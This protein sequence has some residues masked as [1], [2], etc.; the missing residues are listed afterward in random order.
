MRDIEDGESFHRSDKLCWGLPLH[1]RTRRSIKA[2]VRVSLYHNTNVL[3][4]APSFSL[5][6][7]AHDHRLTDIYKTKLERIVDKSRKTLAPQT[8]KK[9]PS[10]KNR[11]KTFVDV[12]QA[13]MASELDAISAC[14]EDTSDPT[15]SLLDHNKS[16]ALPESYILA[17]EQAYG[18]AERYL[19]DIAEDRGILTY[20]DG[21]EVDRDPDLYQQRWN[22]A[23]PKGEPSYFDYKAFKDLKVLQP[24][25]FPHSLPTASA[26]ES[27][28]D[29]NE[30]C[31][32]MPLCKGFFT[33]LPNPR[34]ETQVINTTGANANYATPLPML[35]K[36]PIDPKIAI[37]ERVERHKRRLQDDDAY[38]R[39]IW[40]KVKDMA[41]KVEYPT[42]KKM[43]EKISREDHEEYRPPAKRRKNCDTHL[44][45]MH[46]KGEASR[47]RQRKK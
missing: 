35:L 21:I 39:R 33:L 28:E 32:E 26:S 22:L 36:F 42:S 46:G 17:D 8:E 3:I 7:H 41:E 11:P 14:L 38:N 4:F 23:Y 5:A 24:R 37:K 2:A 40:P 34:R 13:L 44:L 30:N 10:D 18:A 12:C 43:L 19:R 25:S 45:D 31:E 15:A 6:L 27:G 20:L 29:C 47:L 9:T 16:D 1:T